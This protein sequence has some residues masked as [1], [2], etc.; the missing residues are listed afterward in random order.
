MGGERLGKHELI[1]WPVSGSRPFCG[2]YRTFWY[3]VTH[4]PRTGT[5]SRALE[6]LLEVRLTGREFLFRSDRFNFQPCHCSG[7]SNLIFLGISILRFFFFFYLKL[8]IVE[9]SYYKEQH[10]WKSLNF[11]KN[12]RGCF[13]KPRSRQ[14]I[15]YLLAFR[16]CRIAYDQS[17]L[18][19][20]LYDTRRHKN[21][22]TAIYDTILILLIWEYINDT[23]R[24]I[25][26]YSFIL[27]SYSFYSYD[28]T[29]TILIDKNRC[30]STST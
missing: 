7:S 22:Y 8:I 5:R 21:R 9:A 25:I 12:V 15:K 10:W 16:D 17:L 26:R 3:P 27:A 13:R 11:E 20:F 29:S 1:W 2:R 23:Y 18:G 14:L 30:S 28:N 24:H 6:R 4:C 19:N